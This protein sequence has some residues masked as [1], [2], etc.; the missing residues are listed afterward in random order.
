MLTHTEHLSLFFIL[1]LTEWFF[2]T[3][4]LKHCCSSSSDSVTQSFLYLPLHFV[5]PEYLRQA[6][7]F[8]LYMQVNTNILIPCFESLGYSDARRMYS[9]Q[10]ISQC[11]CSVTVIDSYKWL[12]SFGC[13]AVNKPPWWRRSSGEVWHSTGWFYLNT[14]N[15]YSS[16][17]YFVSA[18][19]LV[20]CERR[21]RKHQHVHESAIVRPVLSLNLPQY[22]SCGSAATHDLSSQ[23][24]SPVPWETSPLHRSVML[25]KVSIL[26]ERKNPVC[27]EWWGRS[28]FR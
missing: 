17:H 19:R 15:C 2:T 28:L 6:L 18:P 26:W 16:L 14:V 22:L 8:L 27:L 25:W 20:S 13:W 9:L 12:H 1:W 5:S 24:S 23:T 21:G 10:E 3:W 11:C 4:I 7:T